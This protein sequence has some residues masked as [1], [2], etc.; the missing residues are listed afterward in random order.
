MRPNLHPM[1]LGQLNCGPHVIEIA[2][3]KAASDIGDMDQ[4]HQ[5]GIIAHAIESKAF[6][7]VTVD[8]D[9][10]RTPRIIVEL[11][12][13]WAESGCIGKLEILQYDI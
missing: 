10:H 13:W 4:R 8:R 6:A 1:R 2:G 12:R 7:H 9:R 11:T 3:M 5:P